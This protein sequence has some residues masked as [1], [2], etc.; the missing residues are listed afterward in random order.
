MKKILLFVLIVGSLASCKKQAPQPDRSFQLSVNSL[1]LDA[2]TTSTLSS[3]KY[4]ASDLNWT[5]SD[6]TIASVDATGLI[7]ALKSGSVTII[8][9]HKTYNASAT[10]SVTVDVAKFTDVGV[11]EDGSVFAIGATPVPSVGGY[12]VFK[13]VNG[14]MHK[15]PTCSAVR[16]AVSPQGVPWVI[17]SSNQV[18][19]YVNGAWQIM[20][21][22]ASDIGIGADGSIF[23]VSTVVYS[24]SGGFTV[25][26]WNGSAF[27]TMTDC[28]GIHIAV[29]PNGI[30]W[31]VNRSNFVYQFSGS[32]TWNLVS[33][34]SANDIAIG[35]DGQVYVTNASSG[36]AG[37]QPPIYKYNSTTA[38]WAQLPGI[39]GTSISAGSSGKI[40]WIDETGLLHNQ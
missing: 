29:G 1:T 20:P 23:A 11:G 6:S 33:G 22:T 27:I 7:T 4:S 37:Y 10:C 17:T 34:V 3:D 36:V 25:L 26:K 16:V 21:G 15:L 12:N 28:S 35:T 18:L 31:V 14:E 39:F 30:P 9:K 32:V 13:I 2:G 5:S 8:A 24:P 38:T 40:W 19:K